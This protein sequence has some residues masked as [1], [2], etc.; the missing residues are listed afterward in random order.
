MDNV[1]LDMKCMGVE[2]R[3]AGTSDRIE[4]VSVLGEAKGKI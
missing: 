4:R 2:I 3:T 1:E